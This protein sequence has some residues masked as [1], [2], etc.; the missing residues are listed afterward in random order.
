MHSAQQHK[1]EDNV[2]TELCEFSHNSV[3]QRAVIIR[4]PAEGEMNKWPSG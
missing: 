1:H 4:A 2:W 3:S